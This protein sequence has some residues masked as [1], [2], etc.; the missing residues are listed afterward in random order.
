MRQG[1]GS[2]FI[3]FKGVLLFPLFPS[4]PLSYPCLYFRNEML[5]TERGVGAGL[6]QRWRLHHLGASGLLANK[7]VPPTSM[8][9]RL[10]NSWEAQL[11]VV[12]VV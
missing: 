12:S 11:Y 9:K 2:G 3:Q 8:N 7:V 1:P 10:E 4:C 6:Y 5:G